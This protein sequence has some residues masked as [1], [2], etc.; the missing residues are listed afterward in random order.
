[1]NALGVGLAVDDFG[2]GYSSLNYLKRLP[3]QKLK[4]DKSFIR[5]VITDPDD[6]AI[7]E[8][9]VA[10]ARGLRLSV[11]AEGVETEAQFALLEELKCDEVQGFLFSPPL[12]PMAFMAWYA[13]NCPL[14]HGHS[15]GDDRSGGEA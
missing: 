14:Q 7:T 5:D 4:I 9:I 1:L 11:V 15:T 2:V 13:D 3:I 12:A 10:L 8:T 6:R